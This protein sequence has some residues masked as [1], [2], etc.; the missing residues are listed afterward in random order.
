[1]SGSSLAKRLSVSM[2]RGRSVSQDGT[3][4]DWYGVA[5][6]IVQVGFFV[7]TQHE[8]YA[9]QKLGSDSAGIGPSLPGTRVAVAW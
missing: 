8:I 1:M 2:N 3:D 9:C 6:F 7:F 4:C 5:G